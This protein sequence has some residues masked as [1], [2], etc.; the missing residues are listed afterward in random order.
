MWKSTLF[1]YCVWCHINVVITGLEC[2]TMTL[3]GS[4]MSY[5]DSPKIYQSKS[6]DCQCQPFAIAVSCHYNF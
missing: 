6:T 5:H 1:G 2:V 4:G 3:E